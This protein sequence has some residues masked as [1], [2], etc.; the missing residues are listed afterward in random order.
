MPG[1]IDSRLNVN[2]LPGVADTVRVPATL[3]VSLSVRATG[4][5]LFMMSKV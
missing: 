4:A 1:L 3:I 5:V 2:G